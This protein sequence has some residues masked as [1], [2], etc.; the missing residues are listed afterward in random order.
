MAWVIRI[1]GFCAELRQLRSRGHVTRVSQV[2]FGTGGSAFPR[3]CVI[4]RGKIG[5]ATTYP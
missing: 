5:G 4:T 2:D 1:V 3:K